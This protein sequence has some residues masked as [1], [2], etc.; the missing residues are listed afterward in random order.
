MTTITYKDLIEKSISVKDDSL[1]VLKEDGCIILEH[2][3]GLTLAVLSA[4]SYS[5]KVFNDGEDYIIVKGH[6][7]YFS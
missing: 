5:Q 1:N 7:I 3:G 2:V 6:N 4:T